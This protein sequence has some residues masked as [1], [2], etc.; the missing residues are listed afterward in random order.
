MPWTASVSPTTMKLGCQIHPHDA[1]D[2]FTDSQIADMASGALDFWKTWKPILM[3]LC[4]AA[5]EWLA[6]VQPPTQEGAEPV[7]MPLY[8]WRSEYGQHLIRWTASSEFTNAAYVRLEDGVWRGCYWAQNE[9]KD[10]WAW[11]D[12]P[13]V[14]RPGITACM[15]AVEDAARAAGVV[16]PGAEPVTKLV[17]AEDVAP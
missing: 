4:R 6:V 15:L 13:A 16:L 3:P 17:A 9:A 10:K 1:W 14:D 12:V 11:V 8:T 5:R 2:A 7:R